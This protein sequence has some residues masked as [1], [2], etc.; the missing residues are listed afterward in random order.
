MERKRN[1]TQINAFYNDKFYNITN[2][3]F[4][5]ESIP[6]S[7]EPTAD[8]KADCGTLKRTKQTK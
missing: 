5:L 8:E 7:D 4:V 3:A 6:V 1:R 2:K